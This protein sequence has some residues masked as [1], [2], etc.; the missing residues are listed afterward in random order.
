MTQFVAGPRGLH[1]LRVVP[2]AVLAWG[3]TAWA[4]DQTAGSVVVLT[5]A[6]LAVAALLV[7]R[8]VLAFPM[9]VLA[10]V[11]L[12]TAARVAVVEADPL[13]LWAEE[14]RYVTAEV[15]VR[16]DARI[17]GHLGQQ[18]AVVAV[19]VREAESSA[20][21]VRTRARAT[22]FVRDDPTELVVGRR[23][24]LEGRLAPA[25][26]SDEVATVSATRV[27]PAREGPWWWEASERV[28]EGIRTAVAHHDG[29]AAALVPALV[30]GDVSGIDEALQ[31]DFRRAGLTHLTAVSGSNLTIVLG[32]VLLVVRRTRRTG[33]ILLAALAAIAVFVLV[34]RPEPSVQRAAIMGTVAVIA[35][36]RG[37]RDGL[38]ALAWAVLGV[39]VLDPWMSRQAGFILSVCAT[40]GIVLLGPPL[41]DRLERWMP[42][43]AAMALAVPLSAHLACVPTIAAISEEVSL[44]A[45]AANVAAAPAVAPATVL[46]LLGGLLALVAEPLARVSG[47][48]AVAA[49]SLIVAAGR[50]AASFDGAAVAWTRPWWVLVLLLPL[51]VVGILAVARRPV[52]AAGLTVGLLVGI[53]RPPQTGWPP[54]QTV[55][56]ACDVGQGDASV[57][58]TAPGE[59]IVVD[60]GIEPGPVD[61][62]LRRLGVERIRLLIFS[63][64]DADHVAGWRGAIRGRTVDQVLVGPSGGPEVPGVPQV[65]AAPGDTLRVGDVTVETLWPPTQGDAAPSD[66]NDVSLLQRVTVHGVR[67][68][69]TGDLGEKA[70]RRAMRSADITAD[71]LKVAHHG[72]ADQSA[73]FIERTGARVATVSAGAGNDYGHPTATALRLL[74]EHGVQWWRTDVHGD[75]AVTRDGGALRAV[76]P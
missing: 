5:L 42:S 11:L 66:R 39:L 60:V 52:I 64:A 15:E 12:G 7:R 67:V 22:V 9:L 50:Q 40:S 26:R 46:G 28:R 16:Q 14:G 35:M 71:V 75:V 47:S 36:G 68:L 48:L 6:A 56:V 73:E 53:V 65:I 72:S 31:D 70:Q 38:R 24:L 20:G 4:V 69:F 30:S 37:T 33:V 10:I 32:A 13:R 45:V 51:I 21:G 19:L 34:A 61:R 41:T 23:V 63:H 43:W 62:C 49:A 54:S 1:D 44:V 29:S 74:R 76:T 55:M 8:S 57:V 58:P 25:E 59:A 3:A 2:A 27:S 17:V 18:S